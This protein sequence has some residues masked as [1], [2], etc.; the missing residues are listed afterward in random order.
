MP[1][2]VSRIIRELSNLRHPPANKAAPR[3]PDRVGNFTFDH[4]AQ[5]VLRSGTDLML[6]PMEYKIFLVLASSP[7]A[8][9]TA[10]ELYAKASGMDMKQ[11][12]RSLYVHISGLR[13]KLGVDDVGTEQ[14]V[15]I[16]LQRGKGYQLLVR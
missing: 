16:K 4:T 15:Y 10:Q 1:P 14:S 7:E 9:F 12:A 5:R 6:K 3:R 2:K 13:K 11:D 8:F